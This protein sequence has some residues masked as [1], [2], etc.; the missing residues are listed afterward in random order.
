MLTHNTKRNTP[1]GQPN[2]KYKCDLSSNIIAITIILIICN[3]SYVLLIYEIMKNFIIIPNDKNTLWYNDMCCYEST[4]LYNLI[5]MIYFLNVYKIKYYQEGNN[6]KATRYIL[7]L[8]FLY[9]LILM[10]MSGVIL[11]ATQYHYQYVYEYYFAMLL[12]GLACLPFFIMSTEMIF[13][14]CIEIAKIKEKKHE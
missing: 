9:V 2:L 1:K 4:F 7:Q 12:K 3:L 8:C 14:L 6:D 10:I 13:N 11:F 5:T